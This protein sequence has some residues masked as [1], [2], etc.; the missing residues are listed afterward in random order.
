MSGASTESAAVSSSSTDWSSSS[1]TKVKTPPSLTPSRSV[2][3]FAA[4]AREQVVGEQ[5]FLRGFA[6]ARL[7]LG[8]GVEHDL[9]KA[10]RGN[11]ALFLSARHLSP[12]ELRGALPRHRRQGYSDAAVRKQCRNHPGGTWCDAER[13]CA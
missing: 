1:I 2:I 4:D 8:L 5:D 10:G 11:A 13:S 12:V 6:L 3:C 7:A 9:H